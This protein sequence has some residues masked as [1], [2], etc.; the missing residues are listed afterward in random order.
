MVLIPSGTFQMG[1]NVDV[2]VEMCQK[3]RSG[4]SCQRKYFADDEPAHIV[5]LDD[6]YIDQYEVTNAQYAECVEAHICHLPNSKYYKDSSYRNHPIVN[7]TWYEA[8]KYCKWRGG[9]LPTEAEWEKAARGGLK[10]AIYPWR[11][12]L[13]NDQANLC[14]VNCTGGLLKDTEIDDGYATTAP[15]GSYA[16]NGY[17]L[18]DMAGN[19]AE[20]VADHYTSDYYANSP[21]ENPI[22]QDLSDDRGIRGGSWLDDRI[23]LMVTRRGQML[24]N[25][26]GS[27]IGFRCARS[28]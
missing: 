18:Y 14:D 20:W 12:D 27:G 11:G 26:A 3:L 8:T 15:V 21:M 9:R 2:A 4:T 16:P 5:M 19:V 7:V 25:M 1:G 6:Y 28:P 13:S 23:S 17:G 24:R 22:N 10:D